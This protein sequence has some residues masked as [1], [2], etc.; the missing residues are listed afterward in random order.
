MKNANEAQPVETATE[1][2]TCG[3]ELTQ[4]TVSFVDGDQQSP[5][6]AFPSETGCE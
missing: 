5:Q 6:C 1:C 2:R 4:D 3:A